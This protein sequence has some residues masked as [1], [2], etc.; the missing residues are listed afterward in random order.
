MSKPTKIERLRFWQHVYARSSFMQARRSVELL[1]SENPN[2]QS[3]LRTALT[4]AMVVCYARPF[5]QWPH[6]KLS[7]KIIPAKYKGVH[8]EAIQIRDKIIS[9]RDVGPPTTAWGFINQ[10]RVTV[11]GSDL[12]INTLSPG[13]ENSKAKKLLG[14]I[15]VL[16]PMMDKEHSLF[17]KNHLTP[18]PPE[19]CYFVSVEDDPERWLQPT[20]PVHLPLTKSSTGDGGSP[21]THFFAYIRYCT[22]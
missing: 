6:V 1:L 21:P 15:E 9:H 12:T 3:A 4:V 7:D 8:D 14:L 18:P 17:L 20:P 13:I 11:E 16:G 10:V 2:Y 5:K 22:F 19:G